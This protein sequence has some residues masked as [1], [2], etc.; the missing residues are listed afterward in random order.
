M[1]L[2]DVSELTN[3]PHVASAVSAF[4]APSML[5]SGSIT[6]PAVAGHVTGLFSL[7][8]FS[9]PEVTVVA[10]EADAWREAVAVS[11]TIVIAFSLALGWTNTNQVCDRPPPRPPPPLPTSRRPTSHLR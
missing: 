1:L 4:S 6:P 8:E 10:T 5:L 11:S 2:P 9:A 7:A 3:M